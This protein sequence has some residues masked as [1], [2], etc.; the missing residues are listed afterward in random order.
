MRPLIIIAL[1]CAFSSIVLADGQQEYA[2]RPTMQPTLDQRL[3][4]VLPGEEVERGGKKMKIW[5]SA[6]SPSSN[7][8]PQAAQAPQAPQ[9]GSVIVDQRDRDRDFDRRDGR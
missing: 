4:P 8:A 9:I 7:P 6:G 3:P 1:V 2:P 5:S